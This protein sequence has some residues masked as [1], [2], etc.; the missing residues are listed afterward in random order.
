[1]E[2][3]LSAAGKRG[4]QRRLNAGE[5]LPVVAEHL[6]GN[7][8]RL[9]GTRDR[10]SFDT[11]H[12]LLEAQAYRL[13]YWRVASDEI[14][15]RRFF[16]I[17]DPLPSGSRTST[18]RGGPRG[19]LPVPRPR[20]GAWAASTIPTGCLIRGYF[21]RLQE[22]F[23]DQARRL[24]ARRWTTRWLAVSEAP[25]RRRTEAGDPPAARRALY[26]VVEKIQGGKERS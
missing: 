15:Y 14:N 8:A 22:Y 17:N 11:L 5:Q 18:F 12:E 6:R 1:V 9:N 2:K 7:L 23:L 20:A 13:A 16:D 21:L 19:H 3:V 25:L 4:A 10:R 24:A 26:A